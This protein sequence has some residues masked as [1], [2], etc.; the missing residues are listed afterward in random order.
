M[1]TFTDH[2][3]RTWT[4]SITVDAIKRVRDLA[5]VNL[6]DLTAADPTD[7][8]DHPP[9]ALTRL[10][11]DVVLLCDVLYALVQPQALA[12]NISDEDFGRALGGEA[13]ARAAAAF[14]EELAGFFRGLGRSDQARAIEKQQALVRAATEAAS[15][16]LD[17]IDID[18]AIATA[19]DSP[20]NSPASSAST[21]AP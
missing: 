3:D 6:A 8:A 20:S 14:W 21:P 13:I 5:G 7:S 18:T 9:P 15:L 12:R 2:A 19:F 4:L 11:T 17:A 16:Q 1:R 10:Q